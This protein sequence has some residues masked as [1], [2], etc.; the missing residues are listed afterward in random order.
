MN[1]TDWVIELAREGGTLA[2][3]RFR[4]VVLESNL[5]TKVHDFSSLE[6]ATRYADDAASEI[7]EDHSPLAW[8]LNSAF[9][10][11]D[12]GTHYALRKS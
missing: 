5:S 6:E 9:E 10:I 3:G 11:V 7:E 8:I 4:V 2:D 1:P 12:R